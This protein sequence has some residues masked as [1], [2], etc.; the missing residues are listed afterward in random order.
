MKKTGRIF[1]RSYIFMK[2]FKDRKQ[3]RLPFY[4][5]ASSGLYFIT[6]CTKDR[7]HHFGTIEN[8]DMQL[9]ELG[10]I[11]HNCFITIPEKSSFTSVDTFVVMPDH[12]H[13]IIAIQN[14]DETPFLLEKEFKLKAH[15]LS[16][17]VKGYKAVVTMNAKEITQEKKIWQSRFYDRIIRNEKELNTI[18]K[19]I[20]NNP[21]QWTEDKNNPENLM[22]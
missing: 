17:V 12:V 10:T 5:Y 22:M 15:S 6:I 1:I 4:N 2:R 8:D 14:S 20:D 16:T 11:A 21:K 18:R 13:G 7:I 9:S 3:H 19:Y